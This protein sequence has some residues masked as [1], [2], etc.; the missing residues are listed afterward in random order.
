M[1]TLLIGYFGYSNAGDDAFI[2][3]TQWALNKY[4]V[5]TK[6]SATSNIDYSSE[7]GGVKPIY[8][9]FV[10]QKIDRQYRQFKFKKNIGQFDLCIFNGGSNFHSSYSL[11]H[12]KNC[13]DKNKKQLVCG[14][15]VSIGP[16][17]DIAAEQ[18]CKELLTKFRFI[19]VRDYLSYE[20]LSNM[21]L[22]IPYYKTNDLAVI[23]SKTTSNDNI[24]CD[25]SK[26]DNIVGFSICDQMIK[27][28]NDRIGDPKDYFVK[29]IKLILD[30]NIYEK[31]MLIAFNS[32]KQVGDRAICNYIINVLP[33]YR[34]RIL[35][36]EYDGVINNMLSTISRLKCV[37]GMRL[38]SIVFSYSLSVPF[39]II[40]YHEKC[41]EFAKM[42]EVSP[43]NIL[44]SDNNN[45]SCLIEL[46]D[47]GVKV[48]DNTKSMYESEL[49]YAYLKEI[50]I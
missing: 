17:K 25:E 5:N 18:E 31:V 3:T 4:D 43:S 41:F 50:I 48:L 35:Y 23:I 40:P 42:I 32:H 9:R 39:V 46:L 38:H 21:G 45:P 10:P 14:I 49:N 20:R 36:Y 44:S 29:A 24:N 28:G 13:F 30:N 26:K 34:N 16:F 12:W 1:N 37:V 11:R 2:K 47:R 7:F 33:E 8:S 22:G 27:F 15:G 6:L 19:A